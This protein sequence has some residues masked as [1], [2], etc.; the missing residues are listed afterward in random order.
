MNR[1]LTITA[2]LLI[3]VSI[4][5]GAFG[6]HAL[7]KVLTPDELSSFEVGVR[8]QMYQ[9]LALFIL[10][11]NAAKFPVGFRRNTNFMLF[12][13]LL[14]SSSIYFLSIDRL[15]GLELKWLGPITPLGGLLM[16][17]GWV[18]LVVQLARKEEERN[19]LD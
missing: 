18:L 7:K 9:G 16:I 8:Y 4:V 17:T 13:L 1:K 11:I 12:G 2:A 19:N 5:L 3:A 15:M 14:F 6:A 10:G